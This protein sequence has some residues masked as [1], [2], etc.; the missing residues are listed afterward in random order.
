MLISCADT[1]QLICAFVSTYAK[2]LV[3]HDAAHDV[4]YFSSN[5]QTSMSVPPDLV[6][7]V[8]HVKT[9]WPSTRASVFLGTAV[10]VVKQV[11]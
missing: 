3:S 7:M 6:K 10:H 9:K 8:L 1:A 2:K 5:F 11:S 4:S